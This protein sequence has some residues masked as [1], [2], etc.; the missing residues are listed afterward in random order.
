MIAREEVASR[1]GGMVAYKTLANYDGKGQ[2]PEVA[3]TVG[4]KVVYKTESLLTWMVTTFGIKRIV[5]N[6]N[7]L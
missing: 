6:L 2:G 7:H 5:N 1:L 3:F 4:R